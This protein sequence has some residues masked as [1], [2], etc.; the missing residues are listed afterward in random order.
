MAFLLFT[1][2]TFKENENAVARLVTNT[3]RICHINPVLNGLSNTELNLE[4]C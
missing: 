1:L 2:I 4:L 3:P